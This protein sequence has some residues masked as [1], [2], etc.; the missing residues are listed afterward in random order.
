VLRRIEGKVYLLLSINT[1]GSLLKVD[2][3]PK[4]N[5]DKILVDAAINAVRKS[6]TFPS[7]ELLKEQNMFSIKIIYKI[8]KNNNNL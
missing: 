2:K 8:T 6:S 7:S 4:T 3:L 1:D 5:A